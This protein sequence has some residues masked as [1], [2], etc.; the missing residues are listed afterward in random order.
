MRLSHPLAPALA[1]CLAR[2]QRRCQQMLLTVERRQRA[3]QADLA[4]L[5]R[6]QTLPPAPLCATEGA[7]FRAALAGE[8]QGIILWMLHE[9]G[10]LRLLL[11][12]GAALGP[13]RRVT[14]LRARRQP[15]ERA[16]LEASARALDLRLTV[17]EGPGQSRALLRALREG[18]LVVL[19][20]DALPGMHDGPVASQAVLGRP[21]PFSTGP[22]R[23]AAQ[24]PYALLPLAFL[25]RQGAEG[26]LRLF[27]GPALAP[28]P[29]GAAT[30]ARFFQR[31]LTQ[32]PERWLLWHRFLTLPPSA[33]TPAS[34]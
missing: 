17:L 23:L 14:V 1:A 31:W 11:G 4:Q 9:A 32:A 16:T 3:L 6:G 18:G 33:P 13:D 2:S 34:R 24:G 10:Y 15:Q 19:L 12:L 8:R 22:F 28:G 30:A 25:P 7:S 29:R 21:L 5:R 26:G 27:P 20:G